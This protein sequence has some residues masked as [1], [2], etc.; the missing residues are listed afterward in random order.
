MNKKISYVIVSR[1]DSYCGDSV[2]RLTNTLNHTGQILFDN[3]VLDESEVVLVDWA[4]PNPE[5]TLFDVLRLNIHI[6][7]ILKIVTVPKDLANQ[8]QKDSPF[9]EVHAMNVGFRRMCGKYFA[10]IDNDTLIGNRWIKW[11]YHDREKLSY[12]VKLAFSGR[13]NLS[14]QQSKGLNYKQIITNDLISRSVEICHDHNHFTRL[15]PHSKIYPFYGGAVGVMLVERDLYQSYKGF[16]ESLIYMNNMDTEFIN[17]MVMGDHD[18]FNLSLCTDADFY[19]QHHVRSE[20]AA[21]D[22]TQPHAK[23]HGVRKTNSDETRYKILENKNLDDWGLNNE[24]LEY[25]YYEEFR[26]VRYEDE[27]LRESV[28]NEGVTVPDKKAIAKITLVSEEDRFQLS[29]IEKKHNKVIFLIDNHPGENDHKNPGYDEMSWARF[30]KLSLTKYA[31]KCEADIRVITSKDFSIFWDRFE[32]TNFSYYQK[33]TFIKPLLIHYFMKTTYE[34]FAL[35]DLDMAIHIDAPNIFEVYDDCSF[36]IGEGFSKTMVKKNEIFLR[37]YFNCLDIDD[38]VYL[39]NSGGK[40]IPKYNL[41]LGCYIMDRK[42]ASELCEVLPDEGDFYNFLRK[43]NL[44]TN[45]ILDIDG[46]KKDFIDQDLMSYGYAK[47]DVLD[48]RHRLDWK[49][50]ANWQ[51]CFVNNQKPFNICHFTGKEGKEFLSKNLTNEQ[52]LDKF[53]V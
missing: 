45:P 11:F 10:R 37:K 29:E 33:S 41:N 50:N 52:F 3:E 21:G 30:T 34:K 18:V 13:R 12:E 19:H 48:S 6:K 32:N 5:E 47:T 20:G 9:S 40:E 25:Q 22:N 17:R 42:V 1:N 35:L 8:Y 46:E 53:N 16:N 44:H 39:P 14:E 2:G 43:F 36:V 27:N 23:E 4:S 28:D 26:G 31:E 24:K 15:M 51:A 49:W 7:K 38:Y